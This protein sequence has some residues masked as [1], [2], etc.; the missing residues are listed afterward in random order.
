MS[1]EM[2]SGKILYTPLTMADSLEF[3]RL[4]GDQRVAATMR[5]DCPR[6]IKESDRILADYISGSP[7][8]HCSGTCIWERSAVSGPP[9]KAKTPQSGSSG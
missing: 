9:L 3:F 1:T 7:R 4:A 8:P 6:T 5:F 2:K